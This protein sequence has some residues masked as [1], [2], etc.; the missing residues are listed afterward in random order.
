[1]LIVDEFYIFGGFGDGDK[2]KKR[3]FVRSF[4]AFQKDKRLGSMESCQM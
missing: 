3:R 4:V 1:M 2:D